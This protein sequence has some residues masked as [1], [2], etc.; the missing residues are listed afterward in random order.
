MTDFR[1]KIYQDQ[2]NELLRI[3]VSGTLNRSD[4]M[5]MVKDARERA[6]L[7][8]QNLLYDMRTMELP[9]GIL[10]S[11]ILAFVRSHTSLNHER[12]G[13]L[14]SASLIVRHLLSDEVWEVYQY[15]SRNA[16]LQWQFF[17][18]DQAAINWLKLE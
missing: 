10:L 14:K 18:E 1:Y 15:A 9:E 16:G 3:D 17:T 2:N 8:N 11:E 5:R 12:A 4:F 6:Y 13:S 7:D